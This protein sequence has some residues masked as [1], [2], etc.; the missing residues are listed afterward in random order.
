MK[1]HESRK[2]VGCRYE[3]QEEKIPIMCDYYRMKFGGW[4][5]CAAPKNCWLDVSVKNRFIDGKHCPNC[6]RPNK[7]YLLIKDTGSDSHCEKCKFQEH[8]MRG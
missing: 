3:F 2:G 1:K 8:T 7:P 6:S 5:E 4:Q